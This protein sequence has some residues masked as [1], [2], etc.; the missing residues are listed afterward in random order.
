MRMKYELMI[1]SGAE[2]ILVLILSN[3]QESDNGFVAAAGWE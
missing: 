3:L 1:D 2:L